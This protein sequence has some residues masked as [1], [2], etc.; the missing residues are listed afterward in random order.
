MP[1]LT[2]DADCVE[3][4]GRRVELPTR[5]A[6]GLLIY[7]A[8]QSGPQSRSELAE[9]LWPGEHS[10][11]LASLRSELNR[12]RNAIGHHH[13]EATRTTIELL[14][15]EL[16]GGLPEDLA[17]LSA[18]FE[19]WLE[20]VRSRRRLGRSPSPRLVGRRREL[21]MLRDGVAA[22]FQGGGVTVH[23]SGEPG[24]GKTRLLKAL[25]DSV[26]RPTR[27]VA[28]VCSEA[29]PPYSPVSDLLEP[30]LPTRLAG[31]QAAEL[32]RLI[33][34]LGPS[35][36]PADASDSRLGLYASVADI[37]VAAASESTL[38]MAIDDVQW[39]DLASLDLLIFVARRLNAAENGWLLISAGRPDELGARQAVAQ[40]LDVLLR[41]G[42]RR[43]I[44]LGPLPLPDVAALLREARASGADEVAPEVN[45]RT[46][47]NP[48]FVLQ[49]AANLGEGGDLGAMTA[50]EEAVAA[51]L[52]RLGKAAQQA[53]EAA[54]VIGASF[55]LD[56]LAQVTGHSPAKTAAAID[57]LIKARLL[58]AD[59][60]TFAC[61]HDVLRDVCYA[62]IEPARR[63]LLHM[64]SLV[65]E[66]RPS[67]LLRHALLSGRRAQAQSLALQAAN[68]AYTA[69]AYEEAASFYDRA[70]QDREVFERHGRCLELLGRYAEAIAIY[71]RMLKVGDRSGS[72]AMRCSALSRVANAS[73]YT[74]DLART[75]ECLAVAEHLLPLAGDDLVAEVEMQ[76]GNLCLYRLEL[77]E[78]KRHLD[79]AVAGARRAKRPYLLA[80]ALNTAS[81]PLLQEGGWDRVIAQSGEAALIFTAWGDRSLTADAEAQVAAALIGAG[82][83]S[84]AEKAA[85]RSLHL[86]E[87][88]DNDW[89]R[90]NA[91]KEIAHVLLRSGRAS[92]AAEVASEGLIAAR[93]AGWAPLIIFNLCRLGAAYLALGEA[94]RAVVVHEEAA[95]LAAGLEMPLLNSMMGELAFGHLCE[96]LL[97]AGREEAAA[98][99]AR[100]A[101]R[102]LRPGHVQFAE[103]RAATERVLSR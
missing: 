63:A 75:A 92:E 79:R 96:S 30:L 65:L 48:L 9:L 22:A 36:P 24:I 12:L 49:A 15:A 74:G 10:R 88:I 77:D 26:R 44:A 86:A 97:A 70:S 100:E 29:A 13:L 7:L 69:G 47:G 46:G 31:S 41:H 73:L 2:I 1:S 21:S 76:L 62:R 91:A 23:L 83:L 4:A 80:R 11:A 33:P 45:R 72:P 68:E 78:A 3:H 25:A 20:E 89:G 17:G 19:L 6:L 28:A 42:A 99:A 18:E 95:T 61:D 82:Q 40:R 71:E 81:Y 54:A 85:R 27:V 60:N 57:D 102:R 5:K 50:V 103:L 64:R 14:D 53:L 55:N 93:R 32:A 58:R 37:F 87:E 52:G 16:S 98:D 59:A 8:H 84:A 101:S 43:D 94:R 67:E 39:T 38:V 90:A 34:R 51:R 66:R 56:E 35:A